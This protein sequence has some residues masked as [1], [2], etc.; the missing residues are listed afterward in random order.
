MCDETA[1]IAED[2]D[3]DEDED[4]EVDD[5]DDVFPS[6]AF[7]PLLGSESTFGEI[8]H[9]ERGQTSVS[10]ADDLFGRGSC[11]KRT[12]VLEVIVSISKD[13]VDVSDATG[14]SNNANQECCKQSFTVSL[15]LKQ[16]LRT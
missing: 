1:L 9:F 8:K 2:D 13:T 16:K 11:S 12:T 7:A 4:G 6:T 15:S 5:D 14:S 3:D 10:G